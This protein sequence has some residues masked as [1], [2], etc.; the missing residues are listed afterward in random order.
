MCG[1]P[2]TWQELRKVYFAASV[3]NFPDK[4]VFFFF[5][6]QLNL[7]SIKITWETRELGMSIIDYILVIPGERLSCLNLI[8]N[9]SEI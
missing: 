1:L 9:H 4:L 5:S 3:Y 8:K 2:H 6:G 7:C